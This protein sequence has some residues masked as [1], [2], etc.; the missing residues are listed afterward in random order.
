MSSL[1]PH[2]LLR[3]DTGASHA[4][5]LLRTAGY[6]VSKVDDDAT[7]ERLAG[8]QH[9]DGMVVELPALAAI[10]VVRRIE[11]MYQHHVVIIVISPAADTV[12]RLLPSARV[13][14]PEAAEDDLIST[15]DLAL[16]AHQMGQKNARCSAVAT[17]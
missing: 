16:V 14:G 2:L 11:A 17:G 9:V 4:A 10:A 5:T 3:A 12:S 1:V 13:I 8:A 6:M 7:A 15:V